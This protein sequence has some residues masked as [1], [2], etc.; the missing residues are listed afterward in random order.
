MEEMGFEV[1]HEDGSA[2]QAGRSSCRSKKNGEGGRKEA[3]VRTGLVVFT[4]GQKEGSLDADVKK[5]GGVLRG[6]PWAKLPWSPCEK[7]L[8]LHDGLFGMIEGVWARLLISTFS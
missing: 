3:R 8:S 5:K 7:K 6:R 2:P 4:A 1:L